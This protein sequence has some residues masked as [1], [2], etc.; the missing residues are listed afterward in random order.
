MKKKSKIGSSILVSLNYFQY[1]QKIHL[2]AFFDVVG[3]ILLTL[4]KKK[5]Y[6]SL[7]PGWLEYNRCKEHSKE[8]LDKLEQPSQ[9]SL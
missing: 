2:S 8:C 3:L 4:D 9:S 6:C 7:P 5:F 1:Q